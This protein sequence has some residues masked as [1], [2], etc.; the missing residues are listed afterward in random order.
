VKRLEEKTDEEIVADVKKKVVQMIGNY[1]HKK[2]ECAQK[3]LK[4][5]GRVNRVFD[6]MGV[7]YSPRS[8]PPTA[9]EK[10]LPAANVG[11]ELAETSKKKRTGKSTTAAEGTSKGAKAADVLA[12]RKADVAKTTL[13]PIAKKTSQLM[14]INENLI[15]RQTEAA[16]VAAAEREKKKTQDAAPL[17]TLEKKVASKRK[18]PGGGERDKESVSEPSRQATAKPQA[19][20]NKK[21]IKSP[22]LRNT[23][24]P[25][26]CLK[27]SPP[28][29]AHLGRGILRNQKIRLLRFWLTPSK[30]RRLRPTA[31]K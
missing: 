24:T 28:P 13:P 31:S 29:F 21:W 5:Q 16:K 22:R 8:I 4:H 10:M 9:G 18:N 11:S 17:V 19:K 23:L 6:E 1:T 2:W 7:A 15:R 20:K 12:Q 25:T 14:K 3:I 26:K 27:M 30:L